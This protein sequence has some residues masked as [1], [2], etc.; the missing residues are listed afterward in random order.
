MDEVH[1]LVRTQTQFGEQLAHLRS[2]LFSAKGVTLAG[3]TGTPILS[4]PSEGRQLLDIIKG[5]GA[6]SGD[7]GFI[8]SFPMRPRT[9]FP[10]SL[11]K[12]I[13]DSVLTPSLRRALV[14]K[15]PLAGEALQRYD[16][17]RSIGLPLRRLQRYCNLS[18]H[19]GAMHDGK[20]GSKARVLESLD[21]CAPK[22]RALAKDVAADSSKA[23]VL[24]NRNS[25]MET[26]VDHLKSLA[27]AQG[28]GVAT[29]EEVAAFNAPSN[30]RGEK[31]RV[32]VADT[33]QC[34]EGVSFFTVR[35]VLL[36]DVPANPSAL[37]QAVGRSIRMYGHNGLPMDEWTVTT[38]LYAAV[39]P[40]WLQ[41]TLGAWAYRAQRHYHDPKM[42]QRKA[43]RLTR[44]LVKVGV[45]TLE[46]LRA[47]LLDFFPEAAQERVTAQA[48]AALEAEDTNMGGAEEN[49]PQPPASQG[50]ASGSGSDSEAAALAAGA[51][52]TSLATSATSASTA[53]TASAASAAAASSTAS[54]PT[55]GAGESSPAAAGASNVPPAKGLSCGELVK[56]VQSLGLWEEARSMEASGLATPVAL[57]RKDSSRQLRRRP[58]AELPPPR[59]LG[60]PTAHQ[61][62]LVR[63]L[64]GLFNAESVEE[65]TMRLGLSPRTADELALRELSVASA[66][67]VPALQELR[68]AAIDRAVLEELMA[69]QAVDEG[70]N[71]AD[72][73]GDDA[74][75]DCDF[76]VSDA[77]SG[78]DDAGPAPLVLPAGWRSEKVKRGK[79][80]IREW[81]DPFG[82]RY[83]TEAQARRAV[84]TLRRA[85]NLSSL[86]RR[87]FAGRLPGAAP[88]AEAAGEPAAKR[89]R[90]EEAA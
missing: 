76:G 71:R 87:Q 83:R 56:F 28:F 32:L 57:I 85:A 13:P 74:S 64:N 58:S 27:S 53:S 65:L 17:K 34:G 66:A 30:A 33:T 12:G 3:F 39:M 2:L 52:S 60:P 21:S 50:S 70:T 51:S 43:R 25:G 26:L 79:G 89:P 31:F 16:K 47:R 20:N 73:D 72:G 46:S 84:D 62:Y 1:N 75:S 63:A 80:T 29:M 55:S 68:S 35:R 82:K 8:S 48:R 7:A 69:A 88:Q 4:E 18:V 78:C 45:P 54:E 37:A 61:H 19:F 90:V 77:S 38:R 15:V 14:V 9:L 6:P 81:V 41:S 49:E 5:A 44:R 86:L 11:P 42:A 22:L 10:E 59:R 67:M 24:V 40:R 23:V 36:A